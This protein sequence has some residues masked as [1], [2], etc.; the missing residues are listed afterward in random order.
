[1]S[2]HAIRAINFLFKIL[3]LKGENEEASNLT[4]EEEHEDDGGMSRKQASR[5]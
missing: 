5:Q 4:E 3:T 2:V 1:M